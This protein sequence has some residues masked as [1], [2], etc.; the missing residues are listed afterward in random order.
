MVDFEDGFS[1]QPPEGLL[2]APEAQWPN[3]RDR[4][5]GGN[6]AAHCELCWSVLRCLGSELR[7]FKGGFPPMVDDILVTINCAFLGNG[8]IRCVEVKKATLSIVRKA[9]AVVGVAVL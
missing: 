4:A 5:N 1:G 7:V 3:M 9:A 2:V 8:L 6:P